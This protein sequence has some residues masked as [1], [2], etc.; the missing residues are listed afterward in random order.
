MATQNI[1][2]G[3][4]GRKGCGKSTLLARILQQSDHIVIWDPLA[5]HEFCPNPIYDLDQLEE[6]FEW[7][8]KMTRGEP[9][10]SRFIPQHDMEE[11]FDGFCFQVYQRGHLTVAIEEVPLLASAGAMPDEF[12]RLVR[13]ARHRH[14]NIFYTGQRFSELPRTLT[15]LSDQ[16]ALFAVSE[17]RD[18]DGIAE[19]TSPEVADE[20]ARLDLYEGIWWDVGTRKAERISSRGEPLHSNSNLSHEL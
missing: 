10:A 1:V 15:A 3:F 14:V 13:L 8:R 4:T 5:E 17:P 7:S 16:F 19:R 12:G 18:L 2:C 11:Q 20:V 6:F 9:F